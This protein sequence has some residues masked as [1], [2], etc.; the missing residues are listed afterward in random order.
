MKYK[1]IKK[2]DYK[3]KCQLD[4]IK[5]PIEFYTKAQMKNIYPNKNYR[6]EGEIGS[7]RAGPFIVE[8]MVSDGQVLPVYGKRTHN[9]ISEEIAGYVAVD[10]HSY[11]AV[12]KRNFLSKNKAKI[13]ITLAVAVLISISAVLIYNLDPTTKKVNEVLR[14]ISAVEKSPICFITI[15]NKFTVTQNGKDNVNTNQG[16]FIKDDQTKQ[17]AVAAD[18]AFTSA[19]KPGNNYNISLDIWKKANKIFE[20]QGTS[21][22]ASDLSLAEFNDAIKDYKIFRIVKTDIKNIEAV[23][24]VDK[25]TTIYQIALNKL[26]DKLIAQYLATISKQVGETFNK[27]EIVSVAAVVASNIEKGVLKSQ[28]LKIQLEIKSKINDIKMASVSE[29]NVNLDA[30]TIHNNFLG[31]VEQ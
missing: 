7:S 15:N 26:D 11:L 20:K 22:V 30:N 6:V 1:V 2:S 3:G 18:L 14:A 16:V 21:Y 27:S 28:Q 12:I 5:A 9:R 13:I 4:K 19:L 24:S 8:A 17:V 31:R 25:S 23:Q 10:E 29:I